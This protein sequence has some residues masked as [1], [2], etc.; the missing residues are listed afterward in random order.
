METR[1]RRN[2]KGRPPRVRKREGGRGKG[3]ELQKEGEGADE[4]E[5]QQQGAARESGKEPTG[6]EG[7][8][9]PTDRVVPTPDEAEWASEMW[10]TVQGKEKAEDNLQKLSELHKEELSARSLTR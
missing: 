1:A 4:E 8:S 10:E 2:S 3:E 7:E 9:M 6:A 5:G